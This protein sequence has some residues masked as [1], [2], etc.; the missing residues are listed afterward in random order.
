MLCASLALL[1]FWV[2]IESSRVQYSPIEPSRVQSR[3]VIVIEF[4]ETSPV[5]SDGSSPIESDNYNTIDTD[6]FNPV[7]SDKYN[8]VKYRLLNRDSRR[9]RGVG[10]SVI[11]MQIA[12]S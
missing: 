7:E 4:D 2:V 1:R 11:V 8:I 3:R 5:E 12:I 10:M 9:T 6:E